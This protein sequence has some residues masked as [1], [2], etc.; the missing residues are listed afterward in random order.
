MK[1]FLCPFEDQLFSV[2][3]IS[4]SHIIKNLGEKLYLYEKHQYFYVRFWSL[5]PQEIMLS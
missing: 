5:Y 3:D 1:L 4:L 2:K